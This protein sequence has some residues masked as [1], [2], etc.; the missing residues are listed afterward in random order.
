MDKIAEEDSPKKKPKPV[1]EVKDAESSEGRRQLRRSN[2]T[3]AVKVAE[4][5]APADKSSPAQTRKEGSH[6]RQHS[7]QDS[8]K[9]ELKVSRIAQ[10]SPRKEGDTTVMRSSSS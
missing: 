10:W 5:D 3:Q 6:S 9:G 1:A 7:R 2:T 4:Y 8:A